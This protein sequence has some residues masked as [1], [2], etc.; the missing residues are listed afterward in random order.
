M[1][2]PTLQR[3]F[4]NATPAELYVSADNKEENAMKSTLR[5]SW[6][7]ALIFS[8]STEGLYAIPTSPDPC[9]TAPCTP[10]ADI[11]IALLDPAIDQHQHR[12]AQNLFGEPGTYKTYSAWD[13]NQ[14]QYNAGNDRS[15]R[16]ATD[17]RDFGH[18]F[19]NLPATFKFNMTVPEW[20]RMLTISAKSVWEATVNEVVGKNVNGV[21]T[22]TRINFAEVPEPLVADILI[23]FSTMYPTGPAENIMDKP[24]PLEDEI[25]PDGSWPGIM[26]PGGG[27]PQGGRSGV[28][29]FWT[30]S[31][32]VLTFNSQIDWFR[33]INADP[34]VA[35]N[36]FDFLTT[37]VHEWGHVIGLD[38]PDGAR[39]GT[40][41]FGLQP[42]R[43]GFGGVPG[44]IHTL[45][46][47]T[48]NGAK[49]LYTTIPEP[50][51][52]VLVIIG[53]SIIG[54][55]KSMENKKSMKINGSDSID[56]E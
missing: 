40:T 42:R 6:L 3:S 17:K 54:V 29:A 18:G 21:L 35:G 1:P 31:L 5:I 4:A 16:K 22:K 41:M 49:N 46:A 39:A 7:T 48:R 12:N 32:K 52:L 26:P 23:T 50:S 28:L 47:G 2:N 19:M 43:A 55:R 37:A 38:H 33:N 25:E 9:H 30:P 10:W 8:V 44:I 24:F 36:Q 34:M 53:I 45:D 14:Y 51:T 15:L 11:P 13:N 56:F 20:A 27:A